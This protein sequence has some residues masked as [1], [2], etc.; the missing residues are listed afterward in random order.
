MNE[1]LNLINSI[2]SKDKRERYK[3]LDEIRD[4][5]RSRKT[6]QKTELL[7]ILNDKS[8]SD[9]W[10]DRY[11]S[12][13]G[14]SRIRW[15]FNRF[16]ELKKAYK[17]ALRLLEDKD[18]RVRIAAFNALDRSFISFF[19]SFEIDRLEKFDEKE[20]VK[21]WMSSLF[22][23]WDKTKA[24]TNY[25]IQYHLMR[26][27][28]TLFRPD[29]DCYLN[30]EEYVKY[31]EIWEQVQELDGLYNEFGMDDKQ[32]MKMQKQALKKWKVDL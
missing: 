3:A 4:L 26:C 30:D 20:V 8:F 19:I 7:K 21:L 24:E 14:I 16:E 1:T 2:R 17:N 32:F 27:V 12:M 13:Y 10:E 29:M 31:K 28:D 25:K 22:S 23:L 9:D 11:I 6:N 15:R 5:S 18:G